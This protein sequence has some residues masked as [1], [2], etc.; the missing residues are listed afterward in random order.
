MC[1]QADPPFQIILP[2]ELEIQVAARA[3]AGQPVGPKRKQRGKQA[4][5]KSDA[6]SK[7]A[8]PTPDL[9]EIPAGVFVC[10]GQPMQQLQLSQVGPGVS[11]VVLLTAVEAAPYLALTKA[12]TPNGLGILVIGGLDV[13]AAIVP[14][15]TVRFPAVWKSSG[16]PLLLTAT[17]LQ[18]GDKHV[19]RG[20]QGPCAELEVDPSALVRVAVFRDEWQGPWSQFTDAPL[21]AI[22]SVCPKLRL[23][24][25]LGCTCEAFHPDGQADLQPILEAFNRQFLRLNLRPVPAGD[26]QLFNIMLRVPLALEHPLQSFSGS[27]GIYFEPRG[28]TPR[29]PSARY[30]VIWVPRSDLQGIQVLKQGSA[31]AAGVARVQERYGL[32]CKVE[33]EQDL[34]RHLKPGAPFI[35]KS[36]LRQF[37]VGPWPWGTRR[38]AILK[39][40][41]TVGWDASPVQPIAGASS[42]GQ[43][44]QVNAAKMPQQKVLQTQVGEVLIVE[45]PQRAERPRQEPPVIASKAV[46][47]QLVSPSGPRVEDE[48]AANDP[49][50]AYLA[51]SRPSA[52][53][54]SSSPGVVQQVTQQV[55]AQIKDIPA[56]QASLDRRFQELSKHLQ[57]EVSAAVNAQ[58]GQ[59]ASAI[60][61]RVQ[62]VEAQVTGISQRVDRQEGT[63]KSMFEEQMQRIEAL[64]SPKR[65]RQE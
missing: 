44:W 28:A 2:S 49:W 62:Q 17:L 4:P 47:S 65:A 42:G 5:S 27:S 26:A 56:G 23:C 7:L 15:M 32:R 60:S 3:K 1:S 45:A 22:I 36:A 54:P 51:K 57:A 64:L 33:D 52:P 8:L 61:S 41:A 31:A 11:G 14:H 35:A 9:V 50:A 30:G 21:R 20:S 29:E 40:F 63:L 10:G 34:H 13:T 16:E 58:V 55:I 53:A 46:L 24:Q 59:A 12:V 25:N 39:V 43:W 19:E 48:L 38:Q 6:S 18:V 37:S